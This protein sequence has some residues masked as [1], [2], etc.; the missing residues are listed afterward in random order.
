MLSAANVE[1]FLERGYTVVEGVLSEEEVEIARDAFHA[2]LR[3]EF[4]VNHEEILHSGM[5]AQIGR[6]HV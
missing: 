4:G 3:D 1:E 2:Q 6:A 5:I